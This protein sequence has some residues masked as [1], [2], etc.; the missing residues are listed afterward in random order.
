MHPEGTLY[1]TGS[2]TVASV[3]ATVL[4]QIYPN[5]D[6]SSHFADGQCWYAVNV[7]YPVEPVSTQLAALLS[8]GVSGYWFRWHEVQPYNYGAQERQF[9]F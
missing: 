1:L 3:I 9:V 4:E 7:P 2:A 5:E 6:S 8:Y